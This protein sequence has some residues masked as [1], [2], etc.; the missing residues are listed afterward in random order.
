MFV[1]GPQRP[2]E[3]GSKKYSA[4]GQWSVVYR[5]VQN[6]TSRTYWTGWDVRISISVITIVYF[7][8]KIYSDTSQ[9]HVWIVLFDALQ[10]VHGRS[11]LLGS[12]IYIG[13]ETEVSVTN[14]AVNVASQLRFVW[15]YF[16]YLGLF[17]ACLVLHA[18][19]NRVHQKA[20]RYG[21]CITVFYFMY[22]H[23]WY[24]ANKHYP[25]IITVYHV[26]LYHHAGNKVCKH[27]L[28]IRSMYHQMTPPAQGKK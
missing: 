6:M 4:G 23:V 15:P 5:S 11:E 27:Y 17:A 10:R 19:N 13:T 9:I 7:C 26:S 8:L 2:A 20:T 25:C 16:A 24:W 22:H 14:F 3:M 18:V 28:N 21:P 12:S 1:A